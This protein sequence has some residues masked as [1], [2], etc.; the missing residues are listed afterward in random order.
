MKQSGQNSS[1]QEGECRLLKIKE[2]AEL[3]SVNVRTV[4]RLIAAGEFPQ[5][6]H[7]GRSSRVP[8]QDLIAYIEKL[9]NQRSS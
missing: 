7:L 6:I 5:P 1:R 8:L 3:L 9:K 2:V 4:W